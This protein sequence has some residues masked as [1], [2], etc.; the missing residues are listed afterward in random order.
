[1]ANSKLKFDWSLLD[2]QGIADYLWILYPEIVGNVLD[3]NQ[4]H[5]KITRHL[6]KQI[7]LRFK[8]TRQKSKT[9]TNKNRRVL[10]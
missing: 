3:P 8:K 9:W 10:L 5:R 6:K 1:M 4:F 2:R 7:P